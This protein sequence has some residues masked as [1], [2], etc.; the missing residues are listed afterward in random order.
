MERS[1]IEA[2]VQLA[3]R[4]AEA[5]EEAL[6]A[7]GALG[8]AS[9][10][11]PEPERAGRI[12]VVGYFAPGSAPPAG[13]IAEALARLAA[14]EE[15][16]GARIEVSVRPWRDWVAETRAALRSRRVTE[17]LWIR[18]PWEEP[19]AA[20]GEAGG[21][22]EG[23][24]ALVIEPAQAFGTGTHATT[25][26]CLELLETLT[27]GSQAG[28]ALDVGTGTGIL[29]LRAAQLGWSPVLACDHDPLAAE[30]AVD[31]ARRNAAGRGL[32]IFAGTV[33]AIRPA[34]PFSLILANLFL[35]PLREHALFF[36]HHLARNGALIVSGV[37]AGDREEL[38]AALAR[39][40]LHPRDE[41]RRGEWIACALRHGPGDAAARG[42]I[43]S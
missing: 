21:A 35:N 34:R 9:E 2:R 40:G 4:A 12:A 32:R 19:E 11:V 29:A 6:L 41:R 10:I 18:P 13:A 24:E 15:A 33:D 38:L 37:Q 42:E 5:A 17:R 8:T 30:A 26:G 43:E 22:H 14:A 7:L 39:H 31:N 27:V 36:A 28:A 25:R 16:A 20:R 1:F 3:A 23:C